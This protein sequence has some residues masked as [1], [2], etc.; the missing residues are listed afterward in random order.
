[1][2]NL[3]TLKTIGR[4]CFTVED[5]AR[6]L[7]ISRPSAWVFCNRKVRSGEFLRARRNLYV[8]VDGFADCGDRELF[9]ISNLIQTPSYVSYATALSYYGLTSQILPSTVEA[10]N[11]VRMKTYPVGKVVFR[12]HF[13]RKEFYFGFVRMDGFF[14]AEPEKALLDSLYLSF[15]GRYRLDE[16][17]LDLKSVRWAVLDK[18]IRRYPDRIQSSYKEWRRGRENL[19][20]A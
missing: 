4:P 18:W 13:C 20:A 11:P 9:A 2:N 8:F 16:T 1:M 12:Y 17:A 5:V 10:Q 7:G 15:L 6:S 14:I 19:T 3:A